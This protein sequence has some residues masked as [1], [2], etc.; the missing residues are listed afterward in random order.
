M[1]L[2]IK[3][4]N[5]I[6]FFVAIF[7]T[8][9][10]F[11]LSFDNV[12]WAK[13]WSTLKIPPNY[14]PFS[15][16]KAHLFFSKCH[17]I[18]IDV[19]N[20]PC[21]LIP[22]GNSKFT[23]HPHIWINI[24]NILNLQDTF[25]YNLVIAITLITYFYLIFS[26]LIK[27]NSSAEKNFLILLFFS[28]S[29][30]LLIERMATDIMIFILVYLVL[31]TRNSL[32]KIILI[33]FGF[34]MKYYPIFLITL[35]SKKRNL[36]LILLAL[37]FMIIFFFYLEN[38]NHINSKIIEMSLP[39]A[40][41]SRTMFKA[42]FHVSIEYGFFFIK[43]NENLF[44]N[45]FIF[46]S[47]LCALLGF[48]IGYF[49]LSN[50]IKSNY[51]ENFI[52]GASIYVGTFIIGAN[53]DYRLIF[54]LFTISSIFQIKITWIKYLILLS[55]FLSFNSFYFLIGDKLSI[56]FFISSSLIFIL[57]FIIFIFFSI[58]IGIQ[59]KNINFFKNFLLKKFSFKY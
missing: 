19:Y 8:S 39:I 32:I 53:A 48:L 30:F 46:A 13:F 26:L 56:I 51:N 35:F 16:F 54:L 6:N 18:G 57:K 45:L 23:T 14:I 11:L 50:F 10:I 33:K 36:F 59:L 24:F 4:D 52:A 37:F 9:S 41:G 5:L 34:F 31:I 58:I 43:Y 17:N 27:T 44:R 7:L 3:R 47:F 40:Y 29:N 49:K 20:N 15:D 21:H 28:T 1:F 2:K 42:V 38:I 25:R 12:L 55:I 22:D